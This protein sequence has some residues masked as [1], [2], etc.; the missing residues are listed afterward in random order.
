MVTKLLVNR[1]QRVYVDKKKK[2]RTKK[3]S[4]NQTPPSNDDLAPSLYLVRGLAL[5]GYSNAL[6]RRGSLYTRYSENYSQE[7]TGNQRI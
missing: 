7:E 1:K 5:H 6:H 3:F 4:P 2:K